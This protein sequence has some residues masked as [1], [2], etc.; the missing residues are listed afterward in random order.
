MIDQLTIPRDPISKRF[1]SHLIGM[2]RLWREARR[3]AHHDD[4]IFIWIPKNAGTSVYEMLRGHGLVKLKTPGAARH[5]FRNAGRV[6]FGHM[7]LEALVD[8]GIVEREFVDG[9]FKFAVTRDPYARAVSL[10]RYLLAQVMF[11]WRENPTFGDFLRLLADGR[12]DRIGLYNS[13][14]LSQCNP[15]VEWLRHSWPQKIY[16]VE[17]LDEF[18]SDIGGRWGIPMS[19]VPH[20]NYSTGASIELAREEQALIEQ[21]YAEDFEALG[22]RKRKS[23]ISMAQT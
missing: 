8:A 21:V 1:A 17:R 13:R 10:Y 23:A 14:G 5:H 15:Q 20:L 3:A 2:L 19:E 12:F 6:T 9:A 4:S 11:N 22:Y 16:K 18:I 7:D